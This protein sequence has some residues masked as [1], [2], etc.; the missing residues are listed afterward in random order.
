MAKQTRSNNTHVHQITCAPITFAEVLSK[1][2]L[3]PETPTG[4]LGEVVKYDLNSLVILSPKN[5]HPNLNMVGYQKRMAQK[6][7][8]REL[9]A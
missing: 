2:T 1:I 9:G 3:T 7:H 4:F 8:D 6:K 5:W